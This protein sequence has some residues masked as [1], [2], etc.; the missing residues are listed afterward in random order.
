MKIHEL[1]QLNIARLAHPLDSPIL[2]DFVANLDRINA[3]AEAASGFV[4]RMITNA[5]NEAATLRLFDSSTLVNLSVWADI[6]SLH[7]YVYRSDHAAIMRRRKE[8]FEFI[9]EPHMVL[10]WVPEGHRPTV[11]EAKEKLLLLRNEGP[12]PEAFTFKQRFAAPVA[13]V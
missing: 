11:E 7:A 2:A 13:S 12:G 9:K 8:W 6:E 3:L 10:W 1:A 4:W 5:D